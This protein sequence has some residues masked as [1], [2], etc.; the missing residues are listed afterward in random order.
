MSEALKDTQHT[1]RSWLRLAPYA[2]PALVLLAIVVPFLRF[3]EYSLLMPESL[4]MMGI[5]ILIGVAI[6]GLSR[7][8]P[9]TLGPILL[10]ATLFLYLFR[11]QEILDA[12]VRLSK[13]I[14][15][16]T[17]HPAVVLIV[18]GIALFA[19]ICALSVLLRHHLDKI[20]V[21]V[22]GTMVVATV[23]LPTETGGEPVQ[24]GALPGDLKPLPPVI[25]II[26]DEHSGVAGLPSDI[27]GSEEARQSMLDAYADFALY[28]HA[29]SR[30]PET[31][32]S[33]TSLLN[34]DLGPDVTETLDSG[35]YSSA[36]KR[37]DW[38]AALREKG[39][40]IKAYQSAW[41]DMCRGPQPADA[42]YTYSFVSPNAI[43]RSSLS[44]WDR[45]RAVGWKLVAGREALHMDPMVSLEALSRFRAD[46]AETPHGVAYIV[47]LLIPHHDYIYGVDCSVLDPSLWH[48]ENFGPDLRYSPA[49]RSELY[50][51]YLAQLVCASRQMQ[52]VFAELKSLGVYDEATIIVHGD[53]GSRIGERSF[54]I[55]DA[56]EIL[57]TT[58]RIDHFSTLLAIK[59][60]S[61]TP[62]LIDEPVALQSVFAKTFL[63][64]QDPTAPPPGDV[65]VR[66]LEGDFSAIR[67]PWASASEPVLG[68]SL[69]TEPTLEHG[70]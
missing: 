31:K 42:C 26:L 14:A 5:A 32:F 13:A 51:R 68:N 17:G 12:S 67:Y 59:T 1:S 24:T 65:F 39:Y 23:V 19:A 46:I 47:H 56:E 18:I 33:L 66:D 62:D 30:F 29:Y 54:I 52:E 35:L 28:S 69:K 40:A 7:L 60:P 20:V 11:R 50:R 16:F 9:Q 44:T 22:F 38:F 58:D 15:T 36:P 21:A 55:D 64:G 10:A 53:H 4:I 37:N 6:G 41:F 34:R 43:Q 61:T 70:G 63:G 27:E 8:R 48:R 3:N 45:L 25:H 49:E 2:S 57:S